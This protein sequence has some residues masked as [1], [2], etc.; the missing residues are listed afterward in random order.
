MDQ[1]HFSRMHQNHSLSRTKPCNKFAS[2]PNRVLLQDPKNV[3]R[4][5]QRVLAGSTSHIAKAAKSVIYKFPATLICSLNRRSFHRCTHAPGH[6]ICV[7]SSSI[8]VLRP[9][10]RQKHR[11]AGRSGQQSARGRLRHSE[12]M[13]KIEFHLQKETSFKGALGCCQPVDCLSRT[14][15]CLFAH[16]I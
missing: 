3:P 7:H 1:S 13:L 11:E 14:K 9:M 4:T 16:A 5:L 8:Q 12:H 15:F 6:Q 10:L 2:S